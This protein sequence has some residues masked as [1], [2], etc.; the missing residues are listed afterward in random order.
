MK[1]PHITIEYRDEEPR[2]IG[3]MSVPLILGFG[4]HWAWVYAAMYNG[5]Y[6]FDTGM[7]PG[8]DITLGISLAFFTATLLCYGAF[9]DEARKVFDTPRQRSRNRLYAAVAVFAGMALL[10]L[11]GL[12]P[13]ARILCY[14]ASGACTGIGSAVLLM[15]YGVSF[16]MCDIAMAS[17]SFA[18]SLMV[19]SALFLLIISF[20][21]VAHPA[22]T[23]IC[24][25]CPF[26]EWI[27]L[28]RCSA[29][30]IDKLAFHTMTIPVHTGR[31]AL[32]IGLPSVVFGFALGIVRIQAMFSPS[33][34]P[35]DVLGGLSVVCAA[36]FTC[37]AMVAA[38][39]AQRH[40]RNFLFRTLLP[41][42]ALLTCSLA[43]S[44]GSTPEYEAFALFASYFM[45]EACLWVM[46]AD[47]A[48]SFRVSTFT[49]YGF[50]RGALALGTLLGYV[51]VGAGNPLSE[52]IDGPVTLVVVSFFAITLGTAL[53]PTGREMRNTL[54]RGQYCPSLFVDDDITVERRFRDERVHAAANRETA[55]SAATEPGTQAKGGAGIET[56]SA[57]RADEGERPE[58]APSSIAQTQPPAEAGTKPADAGKATASRNPGWFKRKCSTAAEIYL[59]SRRETEVLFLL[60]KGKN[61]AAIQET[62]YISAGTA[63]THMRHI[64]RKLDVHSQQELM[65]LIAS[66]SRSKGKRTGAHP[67]ARPGRKGYHA[68]TTSR[69]RQACPYAS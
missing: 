12:L 48:Q 25:A 69:A 39:L 20:E 67:K 19:S 47:I 32:R 43:I 16:S 3:K 1:L 51:L 52:I 24:L 49:A 37:C 26:L 4:I 5:P 55:S 36:A 63:N 18:L 10:L 14:A 42:V 33:S 53:L 44:K 58:P 62:L 65:A 68:Q 23:I 13:E 57:A 56:G 30:L 15:S 29:Q 34:S 31:F 59:L 61:S 7:L 50:G 11:A 8:S 27:C 35:G 45:L 38:T 54:V 9:L 46:Y 60:A 2:A 6:L 41:V 21:S 40:S 64:Y 66:Q 22:G 17:L 28:N